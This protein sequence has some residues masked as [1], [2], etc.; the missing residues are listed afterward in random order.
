MKKNLK[1]ADCCY[2][3][4]FW[5]AY[6][7][8]HGAKDMVEGLEL[9]PIVPD[10]IVADNNTF[11]FV[12]LYYFETPAVILTY[13][14]RDNSI[15]QLKLVQGDRAGHIFELTPGDNLM[16]V[17][18]PLMYT[19]DSANWEDDDWN[20][21]DLFGLPDH[22]RLSMAASPSLMN[23]LL[24]AAEMAELTYALE[25]APSGNPSLAGRVIQTFNNFPPFTYFYPRRMRDALTSVFSSFRELD[26]AIHHCLNQIGSEKITESAFNAFCYWHSEGMPLPLTNWK[27]ASGKGLTKGSYSFCTSPTHLRKA[28]WNRYVLELTHGDD[29]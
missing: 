21:I 11:M 1:S 13:E 25:L 10:E 27:Y 28:A 5:N 20:V 2:P 14:I 24:C 4:D 22:L 12:G 7:L 23:S 3:K 17:I 15:Y 19:G 9:T 6:V 16:H 8:S 29:E 18:F 26:F